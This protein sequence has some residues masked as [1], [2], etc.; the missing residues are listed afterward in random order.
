MPQQR[1]EGEG[2]EETSVLDLDPQAKGGSGFQIKFCEHLVNKKSQ[3]GGGGGIG[4]YLA[5][6]PNQRTKKNRS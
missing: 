3:E 4:A 5:R 6:E 1:R 2:G